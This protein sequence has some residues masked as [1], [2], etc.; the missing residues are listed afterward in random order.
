SYDTSGARKPA[1]AF[2]DLSMNRI[3]PAF[4]PDL[5][6]AFPEPWASDW[7]EDDSGL[8]MGFRVEG[9]RQGLRW[10]P[11]GTFLMGSPQGEHQRHEDETQHQVTLSQ[12]FWL[13]DTACTQALWMAVMGSNPS[14]FPG[15]ERPVEQVSWDH[16]QEFLARLNQCVPGLNATLPSEAQWEYAC[17]AG[18]TS[19]FSFGKTVNTEQ[20]NYHGNFPYH[21]QD[22]KGEYRGKT[23]DVKALP[24]NDWGLYQMHGNVWEWCRDGFREYTTASV[25]DPFGPEDDRPRV[26]R[27]GSWNYFAWFL[28]CAARYRWRRADR[29]DCQG[30][31]LSR[32]P[33]LQASAAEPLKKSKQEELRA[34]PQ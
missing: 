22:P 25:V 30:F 17:R 24:P 26:A 18:T 10:I 11:P 33:E 28:R 6:P 7:G 3:L 31:R 1:G 13:A 20:A 23:V 14:H 27:G 19:P 5:P 12:G 34:E 8:W 2:F 9:V 15:E 29:S 32:G 4:D 16:V 21:D